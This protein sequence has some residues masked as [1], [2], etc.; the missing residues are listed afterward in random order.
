[1]EWVIFYGKLFQGLLQKIFSFRYTIVRVLE[2]FI[3]LNDVLHR[4]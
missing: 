2:L 4:G 1:M 3:Y